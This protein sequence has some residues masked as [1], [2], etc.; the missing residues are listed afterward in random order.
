MSWAKGAISY[1]RANALAFAGGGI[2]VAAA[3]G[4]YLATAARDIVFGDTPELTAVALTFGVA[5]PP[6]YPL[7]TILGWLFGQLPDGP[8]PFRVTL[9]S[10]FSHAGTVGVIYA[11]TWRFSRSIP[12]A[13][14]AALALAFEP[15]FWYW[16]LAA[17][18]FPLN[19]LLSATMLLLVALWHERPDRTRLLIAGG[20][21]G[22]LGMSDH[23]TIALLSPAVFYLMWRHRDALLGEPRIVVNTGIAFVAGLVPYVTLLI[24]ASRRPAIS[25]GDLQT[26]ADLVGHFF[27]SSYGTSSLILDPKFAGGSPVERVVALFGSFDPVQW[28]LLTAGTIYAWRVRPWF[29]RYLVLAFAVAGPGFIAYTNANLTQE[30]ARAVLERFFLLPHVVIAPLAG[31]AVVL[32]ADQARRVHMPRQVAEI[33]I[34]SVAALAV[35]AL[36]PLN[37]KGVDQSHNEVARTFGTDL[38]G[39]IKPHSIFLGAGDPVIFTVWY[40]QVVEDA[41]PDVEIVGL[42]LVTSEWYIREL[43]R[44]YPDLRLRHATYGPGGASMRSLIDDNQDRPIAAIGDLPDDSTRASYWYYSRGMIYEVLPVTRTVLLDDMAAESEKILAGYH[45]PHYSDFLYPYRTWERLVMA[46][47]SLGYFRVGR[48][49]ETGADSIKDKEPAR[50]ADLH[51][52][53]KRWYHRAL[54]VDPVLKEAQ[55]G[56]QRLSQ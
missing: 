21:V 4:L 24:A 40:M 47:Y 34:A 37:Y 42:P 30:P 55:Q 9:L 17:E 27:R 36:V 56:L 25:W 8:L 49:F 28:I 14:V 15:L 54:D 38:L 11:M 29:A 12:A 18:V 53:A 2:V 44:V 33:A 5:H 43:R 20:L 32:A 41:R 46:D 51:E 19:D 13:A 3:F 1:V 35:L 22:G 16:S 26:P 48:E 7:F 52:T 23:Q 45:P 50:A 31:F 6:G 10:V 39:T